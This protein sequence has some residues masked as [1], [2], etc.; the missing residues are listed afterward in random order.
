M[1]ALVPT[2]TR[3]VLIALEVFDPLSNTIVSDGLQVT[4]KGLDRDPLVNASGRFVWLRKRP[5]GSPDVWPQQIAIDPGKLPFER[6]VVPTAAPPDID[7]VPPRDRLVRLALRPT[8]AA[9]FAAGVT[10]IRG[11]LFE[12]S[13]A[14]AEAVT[15]A[16]IQLAWKNGHGNWVPAAPA[17]SRDAG[18]NAKGEFGAFF[19]LDPVITLDAD[20]KN[21]MVAVRLQV[22]R[23][24]VIR[25]TANNF[26]FL[27]DPQM[28]GRVSEG[29]LLARDLKLSWADLTT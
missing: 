6:E 9:D 16:R 4:A 8:A 20:I 22:T 24:G 18:T 2:I 28:A 17:T 1:A 5:A 13:S 26:P 29:H 27:A 15:D 10:A 23:Q 14:N 25:S 3:Q 19:R 21:G 7:K 12:T 11:Q